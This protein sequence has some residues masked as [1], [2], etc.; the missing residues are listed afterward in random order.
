MTGFSEVLGTVLGMLPV[1]LHSHHLPGRYSPPH[2]TDQKTQLL[3][4]GGHCWQMVNPGSK[5]G[6]ARLLPI[7]T[8]GKNAPPAFIV[9]SA[10]GEVAW[11]LL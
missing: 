10:A 11:G 2:P 7:V 6:H 3:S 4:Q 1:N 9:P 5:P 8:N